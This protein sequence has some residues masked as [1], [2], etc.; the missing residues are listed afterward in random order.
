MSFIIKIIFTLFILN[1]CLYSKDNS[2]NIL[3]ITSYHTSLPWDIKYTEGIF[4]VKKENTKLNIYKE[5]LDSILFNEFSNK[6]FY[7]YI[8]TKYNSIKID[9]IITESD[10]AYNFVNKYG[11]ELFEDIPY[12]YYT[13]NK[14]STHFSKSKNITN[15]PN[16]YNTLK[17]AF[18]QNPNTNNVIVIDQEKQ[19][20]LIK[21]IQS[22]KK[23][24][25][26][27]DLSSFSIEEIINICSS[28]ENNTFIF[29][30]VYFTDPLGKIYKPLNVLKNISQN[31]NIPI[32]SIYSPYIN[33]GIVGGD[34][35]YSSSLSKESIYI[36][37]NLINK[38]LISYNVSNTILDN[39][40]MKKYNLKIPNINN[41][42]I[43]NIKK[44]ND[45]LLK[46][47]KE[48]IFT[49]IIFVILV[50]LLIFTLYLNYSRKKLINQLKSQ[51]QAIINEKKA[52]Y[53]TEKILIQQSKMAALGDMLQNIAHQWRQ[54]LSIIS[55]SASG[56]KL[57]R[58][59]DIQ[60]K[61]QEIYSLDKILES[62]KYLSN[63]IDV[64]RNFFKPSNVKEFFKIAKSV[65]EAIFLSNIES[66]SYYNIQ[67][68]KNYQDIEV[69]SYKNEFIQVI[70]NIINN[71]KDALL[72]NIQDKEKRLILVS[73]TQQQNNILISIKDNAKGVPE[74][75]IDKIFQPYFTTKHQSKGTGI[76][77]FMSNEIVTK[78]MKG[79]LEVKNSKYSFNKNDYYGAEFIIYLPI[80]L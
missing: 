31:L 7:N 13:T 39:K 2:K 22:F 45:I 64:F 8:K 66:N 23:D 17:I 69:N 54:P 65:D 52:K 51:N 32:Y 35:L 68:E 30:T 42:K 55:T 49:G 67:I 34:L 16:I 27:R 18:E 72:Q 26:V 57:N 58:Q 33:N 6:N 15:T 50:L 70:L 29:Y 10:P 73:V 74:A 36:I 12:V 62:T 37:D 46:Y 61:E 11:K 60:D 44:E 9:G 80:K 59:Y 76:G 4:N 71:S 1:S 78:H 41:M 21:T 19:K 14:K 25:N 79:K 3:I 20:D 56:I 43:I 28:V 24:I 5:N 40:L 47:K 75:I 77:L 38:K 63:T 53:K 48:I